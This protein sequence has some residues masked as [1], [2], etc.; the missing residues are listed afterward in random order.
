MDQGML[1]GFGITC[2]EAP[3]KTSLRGP[4]DPIDPLHVSLAVFGVLR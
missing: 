3:P 2:M 1:L 4:W